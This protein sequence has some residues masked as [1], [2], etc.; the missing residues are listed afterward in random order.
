MIA[1][2]WVRTDMGGP[3]ASLDIETSIT[4]VVDA[5]TQ[6]SGAGGVTYINYQNQILPW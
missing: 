2:G 6:R 5:M 4:G 3:N 1:P